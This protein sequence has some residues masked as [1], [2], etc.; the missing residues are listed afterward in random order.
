M[1]QI[2]AFTSMSTA[3][4]IFTTAAV[5]LAG[6]LLLGTEGC[7][8]NRSASSETVTIEGVATARGNEP[9]SAYV[10][11]AEDGSMYILNIPDSIRT[12]FYT[13]SRLTVTG[14]LYED[15]WN[16]SPF[17]HIEVAEWAHLDD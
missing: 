6:V 5:C 4:R 1:L 15:E 9:F 16:G 14:R 17:A 7:D 8:G 2:G 10:L 3:A 13:P 11:E 12:D